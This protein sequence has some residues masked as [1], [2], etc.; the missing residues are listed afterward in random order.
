MSMF[1]HVVSVLNKYED[2]L[3]DSIYKVTKLSGVLYVESMSTSKAL[4][5]SDNK[6]NKKCTIP[7]SVDTNGKQFLP[8]GEYNK[9]AETERGSYWTLRKDD[10]IVHGDVIENDITLKFVNSNYDKKLIISF[11]DTFDFGSLRHWLVGGA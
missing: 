3:G 11:V 8:P 4:T 1:P 7:F 5:G 2:D 10:I 9:V 6:D